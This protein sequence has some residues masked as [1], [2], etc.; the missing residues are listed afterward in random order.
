MNKGNFLTLVSAVIFAV[1][2]VVAL[3]PLTAR[4]GNTVDT[5]RA[6]ADYAG[7]LAELDS[8]Q[9]E[10]LLKEAQQYNY[11]LSTRAVN[12]ILPDSIREI[13]DNQLNISGDGVMGYIKIPAIDVTLPIC[14]GTD[15]AVLSTSVGH[16]EWTSL[17][18]GGRGT[19]SV[20]SGHNGLRSAELLRD[21]EVLEEGDIFYL[22]VLDQVL[23][24]E[25]DNIVVVEPSET[26]ALMIDEKRDYCTLMTCTPYGTNTHRL[27]VRGKRIELPDYA[28]SMH[29]VAD[30][31]EV[32]QSTTAFFIAVPLLFIL[33]IAVVILYLSI[34]ESDLKS[35]KITPSDLRLLSF[36]GKS[37]RKK[38]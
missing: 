14:H 4:C 18:V 38:K 29:V 34:N 20:L 30:A 7:S 8:Q 16:L 12:Y 6:I 19:H 31:T 32:E 3:L 10:E 33:M 36:G 28:P 24:Y 17:P 11:D 5:T 22:R 35:R 21:L 27:L 37:E 9:C 25:V 2:V 1:G 26:E 23:A 13:Y 15:E